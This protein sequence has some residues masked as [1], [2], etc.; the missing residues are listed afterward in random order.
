MQKMWQKPSLHE[1]QKPFLKRKEISKVSICF[2]KN[3][4]VFFCCLQG[5]KCVPEC[6]RLEPVEATACTQAPAISPNGT[7]PEK[8]SEMVPIL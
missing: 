7:C 3:G 2:F 1:K 4:S 6:Q 8:S 5:K